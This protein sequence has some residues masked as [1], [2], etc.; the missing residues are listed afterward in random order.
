MR[1]K[2]GDITVFPV[3]MFGAA[4]DLFWTG[5]LERILEKYAWLEQPHKQSFYS[6]LFI[7]QAQGTAMIDQAVVRLDQPK[8]ICVRPDNVF[9]LD[10]NREATGSIVCFAADFF[11]LRYNNNVLYQ[12]SFL[13]KEMG[14]YIRPDPPQAARWKVLTTFM[15]KEFE[16]QQKGADKVLRSYLNILLCELDR[17]FNTA[18]IPGKKDNKAEK[19]RQ[20][21]VL[22]EVH[23]LTYK[24]PSFYAKQLHLTTNYLNRLCRHYRMVSSGELIRKRVAIE[25][26]RLL[27]YTVQSV[28]EIADQLGFE[29]TSYFITFFKKNTGT[30]PEGFR[31]KINH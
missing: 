22:L 18:G 13:Q 28:A 9:R 8:I 16:G 14:C 10:I 11:S 30:T 5:R 6:I 17:K 21:E 24:A 7:E 15:Q 25:A 26:Q 20:F 29:S 4:Y 27:Q 1:N 31:K 19:V 23:Y 2:T 3:S 12:F